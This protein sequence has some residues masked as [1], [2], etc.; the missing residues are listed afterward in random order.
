MKIICSWC[1]KFL[2]EKAPF[3]DKSVSHA[4]CSD[5]LKKQDRESKAVLTNPGGEVKETP[6]EMASRLDQI[7][8]ILAEGVLN[9]MAEKSEQHEMAKS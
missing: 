9:L 2:G 5:C 6:A 3:D 8:A 7:A 4:K 1:K